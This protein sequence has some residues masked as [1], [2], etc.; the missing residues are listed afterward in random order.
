M[1]VDRVKIYI[2][3]YTNDSINIMFG[4]YNLKEKSVFTDLLKVKNIGIK[5]AFIIL[6][7]IDVDTLLNAIYTDNDE[8]LLK[9]P[10]VCDKNIDHLKKCLKK[11]QGKNIKLEI[12]NSELFL[13]LKNLDY[14]LEDILRV[15][16][17]VNKENPVNI[18]V[19]EAI[20]Y[21]DGKE[22]K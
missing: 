10:K 19:K 20:K 17:L 21:L 13:L 9:I 1:F 12:L 7:K 18:Q 16:P 2:Y 22:S 14:P 6:N 3:H 4:F 15:V 5:S 8:L 11:E